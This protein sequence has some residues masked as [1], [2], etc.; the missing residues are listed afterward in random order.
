MSRQPLTIAGLFASASLLCACATVGPDY[1]GPPVAAP[2]ET[3]AAAFHRAEA[4][5]TT[6][7]PP[8]ARWWEPLHDPLLT[9]LI[10]QALADS[11]NVH[12]AEA[13]VR[14]ARANLGASRAQ[15]L[16]SGG[17]TATEL[18]ARVPTGALGGLT[19]GSGGGGSV[20][21]F[22]V[23]NAGFDATWELDLFG[24]TRRGIE[25]A[26][27]NLGAEQ[28]SLQDAEV[29]LAAEVGQTYVN[30]RDAQARL[31]LAKDAVALQQKAVD[32]VRQRQTQ[33]AAADGDL[34]RAQTG[35]EQAQAEVA[36][37]ESQ[38]DQLRDALAVL[39]GQEPGALDTELAAAAPVPTPP[40]ETAVGDPASMLRRRPDIRQ[41]ERQLAA[42]NARIGQNM[43]ELF[44]K[45]KLLGDIGFSATDAGQV[46]RA[47]NFAALGGPSLSWNIVSYPRI[48]AQVKG[49]KA[50][51]DAAAAQYQAT[52]LSA[53]QDA[54]GSLSRY[55]GQ[56]K[57]LVSLVRAEASATRAAEITRRRYQA[58]TASLLDLLDA[59]RQ[60]IQTR[61]ALAQGEAGLTSDWIALQ[62]SLGLGWAAG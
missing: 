13:K 16:P 32:L 1:K 58:G 25:A 27:A 28:A 4:A 56:R 10:D 26:G 18:N 52:V 57:S 30:L 48:Q 20:E 12:A 29:Q 37:L 39:T 11:P 54:E 8:P 7:A 45:V 55:G 53:L 38:T 33:G 14:S 2:H 22:N 59:Q 40:A 23:Y 41:A 35:L 9:R 51:R 24:G 6:P 44:P 60:Q 50:D 49:A 3:A 21:S 42:S 43:A 34:E 31:I 5:P 36:P 17:A 46:F 62:K 61:Q 47:S 19:G 15:L